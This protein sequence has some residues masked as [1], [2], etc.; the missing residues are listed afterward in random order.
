MNLSKDDPKLTAYALNEIDDP[1]E[2]A[3][4]EVAVAASE[5]LQAVVAEIRELAALLNDGLADEP[6]PELSEFEKA[7]LEQANP[8]GAS[9][10][11]SP[12][13]RFVSLPIVATVAAA[14][15]VLLVFVAMP[16]Y[17]AEQRVEN[18]ISAEADMD[19]VISLSPFE[20]A[21]THC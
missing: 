17:G 13:A 16:P 15:A 21:S 1:Q 12:L 8:P 2:R 10:T 20:V 14:A 3:E 7:R 19:E 9:A 11:P 18:E 5:D 6:R 4:I